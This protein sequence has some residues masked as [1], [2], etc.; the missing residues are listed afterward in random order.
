MKILGD[1][2]QHPTFLNVI[3]VCHLI[4]VKTIIS[5]EAHLCNI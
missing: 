2:E 4:Q 1:K 5:L 3:S